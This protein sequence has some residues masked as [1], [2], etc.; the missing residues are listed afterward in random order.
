MAVLVCRPQSQVAQYFEAAAAVP[1]NTMAWQQVAM[2]A[3]ATAAITPLAEADT[4]Q[5]QPVQ[6]IRAV[7]AAAATIIRAKPPLAGQELSSCVIRA[8]TPSPL[9]PD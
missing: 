4:S 6:P 2:A 5:R 8:F 1:V 3:V 7:E 9:E